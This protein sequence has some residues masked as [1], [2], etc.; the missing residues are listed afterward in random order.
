MNEPKKAKKTLENM[1]DK[2]PTEIKGYHY[3][4]I[5]EFRTRDLKNAIKNF[6]KFLLQIENNSGQDD[7]LRAAWAYLILSY[8]FKG[9]KE[10][11][12]ELAAGVLEILTPTDISSLGLAQAEEVMLKVILERVRKSN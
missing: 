12:L 11:A 3:I 8:N 1:I 10:K 6:E 5:L 7:L 4:G 9:D 2:N